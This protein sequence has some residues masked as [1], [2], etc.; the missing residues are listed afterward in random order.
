MKVLAHYVRNNPLAPF[1][2]LAMIVVPCSIAN[3]LNVSW[4]IG[5]PIG[6][7]IV[8]FALFVYSKSPF[9]NEK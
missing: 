8:V 2:L 3:S 1:G 6:M 9:Y 7:L 5:I 4:I